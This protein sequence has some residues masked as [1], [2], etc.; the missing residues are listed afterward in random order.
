M[1]ENTIEALLTSFLKLEET[2]SHAA[3]VGT[4]TRKSNETYKMNDSSYI[5]RA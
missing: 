1:A 4:V 2:K 3:A 5:I